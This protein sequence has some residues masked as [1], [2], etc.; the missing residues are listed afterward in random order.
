[1]TI[2]IP[3]HDRGNQLLQRL[4]NLR[5][6]F[7]DAEIEIAISKNG[8]HYYQ[9]EYKNAEKMQREDARINYVGCNEELVVSEN[10]RRVIEIAKENLCFW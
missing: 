8:S 4:G 7:L 10:W 1:M 6:L 2:G 9:E 5:K 3:T